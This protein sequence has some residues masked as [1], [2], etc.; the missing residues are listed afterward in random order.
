MAA[1]TAALELLS[2]WPLVHHV[3][4]DAS[5]KHL[6]FSHNTLLLLAL[7]VP[8]CSH[9]LSTWN[10]YS[11]S[12]CARETSLL[13]LILVPCALLWCCT[14]RVLL[15]GERSGGWCQRGSGGGCWRR[16]PLCNARHPILLHL[17]SQLLLQSACKFSLSQQRALHGAVAPKTNPCSLG[18]GNTRLALFTAYRWSG[19][20][21]CVRQGGS[22]FA[23]FSSSQ[24]PQPWA[25]ITPHSDTLAVL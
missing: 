6:Y 21:L 14:C 23:S 22:T 5:W 16:Q 1:T 3:S 9:C 25:L 15:T 13:C 19:A 24:P 12:C 7:R 20:L 11:V 17:L 10:L 4:A 2:G 18:L 8:F